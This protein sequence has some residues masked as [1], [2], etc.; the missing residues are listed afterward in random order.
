MSEKSPLTSLQQV[1][2]NY[3]TPDDVIVTDVMRANEMDGVVLDYHHG[4]H[5]GKGFWV[6]DGTPIDKDDIVDL[7]F[8]NKFGT[9]FGIP[10]D[11]QIVI[12]TTDEQRQKIYVRAG[13]D[14]ELAKEILQKM[15]K[16]ISWS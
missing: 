13:C 10:D 11:Y 6:Y 1:V 8:H 3:G 7:T 14:M 12:S 5:G 15:E 16:S 4:G 2:D 9:A